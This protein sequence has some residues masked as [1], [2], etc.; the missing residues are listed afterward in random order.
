M[1]FAVLGAGAWGTALALHLDRCGHTVTLVSRR[2]EHAAEM[3]S[4][5]EN[6]DYLP[7]AKIPPSLQLGHEIMP[8]LMEADAVILACPAKALRNLCEEIAS[9]RESSWGISAVIAVCKG[10]DPQSL[11]L[12]V[13]VLKE[14]LPHY[15]AG[16]LSGPTHAGGLAEGLPSAAVLAFA[17]DSQWIRDLQGAFSNDAFRLYFSDDP[18]GVSL[19]GSLKNIFAIACGCCDGLGLG[20]NAKAALLTRSLAEMVEIG[21]TLGGKRETFSGLSGV[22]D[23]VA[24]S[25]G[26]WSRNRTFGENLAKGKLVEDQLKDR[27]TVVEGALSV[28]WYRERCRKMEISTPILDEVY[29][30]VYE[31]KDP[32][33]ALRDL[34]SRQL[35]SE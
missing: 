34:M 22:G 30:L 27:K 10:L 18:I 17:E 5:R 7:G 1:N 3:A 13:E 24:T 28:R 2:L 14:V 19:A 15:P 12:P 11:D 26:P 32:S 35:K 4:S 21:T 29:S 8:A 33:H 20:D 31:E 25:Y 9:M 23:L 6:K 16:V